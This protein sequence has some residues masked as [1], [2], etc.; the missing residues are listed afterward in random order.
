MVN[1]D[2]SQQQLAVF[3]GD[4]VVVQRVDPPL[5]DGDP[6][7]VWV[8]AENGDEGW[9]NASFLVPKLDDGVPP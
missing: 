8:K 7:R 6:P 2:A 3:K 5:R 9:L 1:G 4:V